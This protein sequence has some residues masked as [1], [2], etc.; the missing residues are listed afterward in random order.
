MTCRFRMT[1]HDYSWRFHWF[2][3]LRYNHTGGIRLHSIRQ[4]PKCRLQ[5]FQ[6][7]SINAI[8]LFQ[9]GNIRS[10]QIVQ[11]LSKGNMFF[12]L[13]QQFGHELL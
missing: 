8:F 7:I 13:I 11:T 10:Q 12:R 3:H 9:S 4:F 2:Q 1:I 6:D 5:N